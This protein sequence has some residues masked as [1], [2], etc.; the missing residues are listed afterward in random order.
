MDN[1]KEYILDNLDIINKAAKDYLQKNS[2]NSLEL[3]AK[4]VRLLYNL[5]KVIDSI[6]SVENFY[7]KNRLAVYIS[8]LK[9]VYRKNCYS[10]REKTRLKQVI[11]RLQY[12]V[13]SLE[14]EDNNIVIDTEPDNS[15][16]AESNTNVIAESNRNV[17]T[18]SNTNIATEA[19]TIMTTE[20]NTDK[21][22]I[23]VIEP[24]S[25]ENKDDTHDNTISINR[26]TTDS[27]TYISSPKKLEPAA[28]IFSD[29]IQSAF[30]GNSTTG[31]QQKTVQEKICVPG[32]QTTTDHT[33]MIDHTVM[34]DSKTREI[35][36]ITKSCC[37]GQ[38]YNCTF[39][40]KLQP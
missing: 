26:Q 40:I 35:S 29:I 37:N 36:E 17:A 10:C 30:T 33:F 2:I 24:V 23:E 32:T 15:V 6:G 7:V 22:V 25:K 20:S 11:Q 12:I 14:I 19:N 8:L 9:T 39:N 31:K 21:S 5:E 38:Y 28:V 1:I 34:T 18:E 13:N 3:S 16:M 27:V 4:R